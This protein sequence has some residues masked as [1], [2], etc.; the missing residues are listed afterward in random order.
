VSTVGDGP[1]AL[2]VG[3]VLEDI[4]GHATHARNLARFVPTVPGI[5]AEFRPLNFT[6]A[7]VESHLPL[8][9]S[10]W[11]VRSGIHAR[12]AI[13]SM[14][15]D[16]SLDG[17]F[18]HTQV[19]ALM[20]VGRWRRFP[21]VISVDAT[22]KQIDAL[23]SQYDHRVRT[24]AVERA[25]SKANTAL[26]RRA[27]RIVAWSEWARFALES[28]YG[29][30]PEKVAVIAPGVDLAA[31]QAPARGPR[32]GE[33]PVRVLFVGG[34]FERKGGHTL[35]EAA[36]RL[37]ADPAGPS[38]EVHLVTR[39]AVVCG[40]DM[41]VH[42]DLRPNDRTLIELYRNADVF[43][44]PTRGDCLPMALAEAGAAGLPLVST[45]VGAIPELVRPG[46][47]GELVRPDDS[48][49]LAM[50]LRRLAEDAG[51]R[52]ALGAGAASLVRADHDARR[53]AHAVVDVIVDAI[54]ERL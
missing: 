25:K 46:T 1:G 14:S 44:L 29:V 9:R 43:C 36:Q 6:P 15:R 11:S 28:D 50:V 54:K 13:S 21:T 18:I 48:A 3:F 49:E 27:A 35:V 38:I 40:P 24:G 32:N 37:R 47:T 7:G 26:L 16:G 33:G 53:N 52:R 39:S 42:R 22:P 30:A 19:P 31:W 8:Y 5:E 12:R 45:P 51:Y 2:R 34:D 4:L 10:N 23:G 20:S 17:L 41:V